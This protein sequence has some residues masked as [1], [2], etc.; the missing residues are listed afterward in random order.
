MAKLGKRE[1]QEEIIECTCMI[2]I[3]GDYTVLEACEL[4][5][6]DYCAISGNDEKF[7][8]TLEQAALLSTLTP[9]DYD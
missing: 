6:V 9:Q 2:T 8:P 7:V 1:L 5:G 3:A 4:H